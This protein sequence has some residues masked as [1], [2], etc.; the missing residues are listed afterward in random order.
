MSVQLYET[1]LETNLLNTA[2]EFLERR[3]QEVLTVLGRFYSLKTDY[4][5]EQ[6]SSV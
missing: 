5:F 3:P 6:M 2:L 4:Q 1:L